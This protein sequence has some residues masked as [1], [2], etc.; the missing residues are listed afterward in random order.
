VIVSLKKASLAEATKALCEQ[1][2]DLAKVV[3]EFGVPPLWKRPQG[4]R[5]L[6]Y[7]ILEQQVS[8]ASARATYEKLVAKLGAHPAPDSFLVL[9]DDDLRG[10]GFSRQKTRYCRLLAEA[11]ADGSLPI[12]KL[13]HYDDE[14]AKAEMMKLTGIGH[15]TADVY[16]MEALGRPDVWPVGDLALAVGAEKIKNL[17]ARPSADELQALGEQWRPYRAVAARILWHYYLS[18]I[19]PP[20]GGK[21]S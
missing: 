19:R 8:L 3:A 12:N 21:P 20:P 6:L 9:N 13:R 7:L 11:V 15:W 2:A 18:V 4:F 17:K 10:L 14:A 1:D 16:L 5:T